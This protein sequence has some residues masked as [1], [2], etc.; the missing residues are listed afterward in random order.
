MVA[1]SSR[2]VLTQSVTPETGGIA[3]H[4]GSVSG[5]LSD[6]RHGQA[7]LGAEMG[8]VRKSPYVCAVCG[9]PITL[10]RHSSGWRH[11]AT[12]R[13][14]HQVQKIAR[15]DYEQAPRSERG[16]PARGDEDTEDEG[17]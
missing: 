7:D 5:R 11:K 16:S 13:A 14:D 1:D 12:E 15:K 10:G 3:G 2:T 6:H 8:R 17:P 9:Q 4:P